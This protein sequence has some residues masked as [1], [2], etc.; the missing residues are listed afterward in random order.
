ML[1][2]LLLTVSDD[3]RDDPDTTIITE[4][5]FIDR[6]GERFRH[7]LDYLRNGQVKFVADALLCRELDYFGIPHSLPELAPKLRDYVMKGGKWMFEAHAAAVLDSSTSSK[8]KPKE[9]CFVGQSG[10]RSEATDG[11]KAV[12]VCL[13]QLS[14]EQLSEI[15]IQEYGIKCCSMIPSSGSSIRYLTVEA[16]S[17]LP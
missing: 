3:T 5:I 15:W 10:S 13:T 9:I 8:Q 1:A 6:D 16:V 2:Q 7:V 14:L 17:A 11:G 12:A 4:D